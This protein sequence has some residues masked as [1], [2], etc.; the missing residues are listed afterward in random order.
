MIVAGTAGVSAALAGPVM[1]A[2]PQTVQAPAETDPSGPAFTVEDFVH[3]G[4]GAIGAERS[5]VLKDGNGYLQWAPCP[6]ET[7][8]SLIR[9]DHSVAHLAQTDCFR[10]IATPAWLRLEITGS[11]GINAGAG[12][13]IV[14][15]VLDGQSESRSV[16]ATC[17]STVRGLTD[18]ATVVELRVNHLGTTQDTACDAPVRIVTP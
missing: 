6:S 12:D 10:I 5:I 16:E 18:K 2:W 13:T 14:T 9:I 3:P 15:S 4:A 7:D 8:K 1:A 11:F 17:R